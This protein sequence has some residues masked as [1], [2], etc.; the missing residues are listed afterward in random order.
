VDFDWVGDI[1]RRRSM[2]RY[3]FQLIGGEVNWMSKR[4]VVVSLSIVDVEYMNTTQAYKEA[5]WLMKLC[6]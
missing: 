1:D 6:L 4:Q 2:R 5:I 3:M